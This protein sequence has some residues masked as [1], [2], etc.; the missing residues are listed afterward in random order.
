MPRQDDSPASDPRDRASTPAKAWWKTGAKIALALLGLGGL[1]FVG[2]SLW[3]S[4]NLSP[5]IAQQLTKSLERDV[6]VGPLTSI[7]FNEISFGPSSLAATSRS[8]TKASVK[9][10]KIAFDPLAILWQRTLKPTITLV[11]PELHLEQDAQG[12]WLKLP[13]S[14]PDQPGGFFTTEIQGVRVQKARGTVVPPGATRQ[15]LPF[16]DVDLNA[17]FKNR[18]RALQLV[19]FDGRGTVGNGSKIDLKG[20][21]SPVYG[22]TNL[23]VSGQAIDARQATSFFKVPAVEFRSGMVDGQL[24]L[25]IAPNKTPDFQGN[26][27][28]QGA[29][30]KILEVPELF[31]QTSGNLI[32]SPNDVRFENVTTNYGKLPGRI[33]GLIDYKK[34]YDLKAQISTLPVATFLDTLKVKAPFALAAQITTN[35]S[36]SGQLDRP[37]LSGSAKTEGASQ[38]DKLT[39]QQLSGN[40]AIADGK[41]LLQQVQA[42]PTSGGV[43]TGGGEVV[44]TAQP[45]INLTFQGSQLPANLLAQPYQT[46]PLALGLVNGTARISGSADQLRTDLQIQAPQA[47]YPLSADL[48]ISPAGAIAIRQGRV[49]IAGQ[50]LTGT[51]SSS[52]DRWQAQVRV[53]AIRTQDLVALANDQS[54]T[55]TQ[56]PAFLQGQVSG[57]L[58]LSGSLQNSDRIDG[59]GLL[60]LAT[61]AGVV[62]ASNLILNQGKWQADLQTS[63]LQLN[64][65]DKQ[66]PGQLAG[67]FR[68]AG[69][70]AA[71]QPEKLMAIGSGSLQLPSGKVVGQNLQLKAGKWQG[72]FLANS[73]DLNPWVPNL[74]GKVTGQVSLKGDIQK[75]ALTD[76]QAQAKGFVQLPSGRV[77][78]DK[79]TLAGGQWQ[80]EFKPEGLDVSQFNSAVQ[81][82]LSG[83]FNLAGNV[84]QTNL[85][86]LVG[87]GNARLQLAGGQVVADRLQLNKG[88]WQGNV[89]LQQFR[90]GALSASIPKDFQSGLLSGNFQLVGQLDRPTAVSL[91]GD[92]RLNWGG[93][94]IAARDLQVADGAWQG[95]FNFQSIAL[96]KLPVNIPTQFRAGQIDGQMALAGRFDTPSLQTASGSG[97]L[98]LPGATAVADRFS[99]TGK[100]WQ[101]RFQVTDLPVGQFTALPLALQK[102]RL[103]SNFDLTGNLTEPQKISGSGSGRVGLGASQIALQRWQVGNNQWQVTA[104]SDR[105]DLTGLGTPASSFAGKVNLNGLVDRPTLAAISGQIE[106]KLAIGG[107]TVALSP[108][109]IQAGRWQG[110]IAAQDIDLALLAPFLPTNVPQLT[111]GRLTAKG[112]MGGR[113]DR[114]DVKDVTID[115]EIALAGLK[116]ARIDIEPNLQG[117]IQANGGVLAL[118]LDGQRDHL[119]FYRNEEGIEFAGN[120]A[121]ATA[122][123]KMVGD[124]L[125]V[126]TKGVPVALALGLLPPLPQLSKQQVGGIASGDLSVNLKTGTVTGKNIAIDQP[127]FG[128]ITGDRIQSGSLTYANGILEIDNGQF[129]RGQGKYLYLVKGRVV[130]TASQPEY[131]LTVNVPNGSLAD[132]TSLFQIFALEDLLDPFG[133]R[134]YGGA[135]DL[136]SQRAGEELNTLQAQIDRLSELKKLR[137][138]QEARREEDPIPDLRKVQGDFK[139]TIVL[140]NAARQGVYASFNIQGENWEVDRYPI[141]MVDLQGKW[142]NNLLSISNLDLQATDAKINVQ[143]DFGLEGQQAKIVVE[144]FPAERIST[145][146]HLPVEVAGNVNLN[147]TLSGSLFNPTLKGSALLKDGKFNQSDLPKIFTDFTYVNARLNFNSRGEVFTGPVANSVEDPFSIMGSVPYRLPFA[148]RNPD[149]LD[150]QVKLNVQNQGLA[151]LSVLTQ[152]Q[153]EWVTGTG[154]VNVLA[155]GLMDGQGK[156]K[157]LTARGEANVQDGVIKSLLLQDQLTAVN[158]RLL[159]DLDRVQVTAFH[160]KYGNGELVAQGSIPIDKPLN[161]PDPL[162]VKL[163]KLRLDLKDKYVGG[164][165]G[166]L[167]LG[168]GSLLTPRLGGEINLSDGQVVLPETSSNGE[169]SLAAPSEASALE[170]QNLAIT[171]GNNVRVDKPP[172]LNF[173]ATGK[174]E[175]NGSPD[176]LKPEGTIELQRGQVNLFTSRFRIKG[177]GN[178]ARFTRERGLDPIVDLRL[179][180]KVLETYRLP[181]A[182]GN[183]RR[184]KNDVFTTSLGA[185]QSIQVDAS[186]NGPASQSSDR[187]ELT[188]NPP[189]NRDE[190]LILLG[191]GLGRISPDENAIGLGL[192][193]LAGSTFITNVQET[194]NDLLGLSDFRIYP[195]LTRTEGST[196]S[197][198]GLAAELGIDLSS[199]FS[200]SVF[201]IIT[202]PELPQYSIRYRIDDRLLLR[203]SSNLSNDS[204]FLLE[205]EQRF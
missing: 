88:R 107:G 16:Q 163:D 70:L 149:S 6:K 19:E 145:L 81:G 36:L 65:I 31:Q 121:S 134:G 20:S 71:S 57:N 25:N 12:N 23:E 191:N 109:Q 53:P 28:V 103:T 138:Q 143:G 117:R 205:F 188:S 98:R 43:L 40:F 122:R 8:P 7:G 62:S 77:L 146:L 140:N 168:N 200:A 75:T 114:F 171:L 186:V 72:D 11:E 93:G 24:R 73:F 184:E 110:Q 183:E 104:S 127:V 169:T 118:K 89:A 159:F 32:L 91:G 166:R 150:F 167:V 52:G 160:A 58:N 199:N 157:T 55:K 3:V 5:T 59:Q 181:S 99:L 164:V 85:N 108:L 180:T 154:M 189:R 195:A 147:A 10:I 196:T 148:L 130:T 116:L 84:Q 66:L 54:T 137:E 133:D 128:I 202:S 120:L 119:A 51:G 182:T 2:V 92:G 96:N 179:T 83:Q 203:G 162:T 176:N 78:A 14:K 201:K 37:V 152:Q 33:N 41:L 175:L 153:A 13:E 185:V 111:A 69:D 47:Q 142:Q 161:L 193:N 177:S 49:K 4:Q 68:V 67:K 22:T 156:V 50:E 173:I 94:Q 97:K 18:D 141:A 151:L 34:G 125:Q 76:L 131:Q 90:L 44:L 29:T 158:G 64:K 123:G 26:V 106:G 87:T 198:L 112:A 45:Q 194:I 204:R 60:Q 38:V 82:R 80:G 21:T 46:L 124:L 155:E 9:A 190:I 115:S 132:V 39:L 187:L 56:L 48:S 100:D 1:G 61:A 27:K 63:G 79:L 197:A 144:S 139:G 42:T 30:I 178:T 86:Q 136:R 129:Q 135:R 192:F 172:V 170:F 17:N 15:T 174:I 165:S 126:Q 101:G 35:L 113:L 102:A 95:N 74:K 105:L